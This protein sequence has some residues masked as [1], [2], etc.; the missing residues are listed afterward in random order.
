MAEAAGTPE[1]ATAHAVRA[2][3]V[4]NRARVLTA[5]REAFADEG[6]AVP[7]GEIARRAGVGAGTVYRHFPSKRDLFAAVVAQSAADQAAE[8]RELAASPDPGP[9]FFAFLARVVEVAAVNRALCDAFLHGAPEG[10]ES[11]AERRGF[12]EALGVL[13]SRA[14]QAGA[15]RADVTADD[16]RALLVGC[17]AMEQ[18]RGTAGPAPAGA[19]PGLLTSV[20]CDGLRARPDTKTLPV[21]PA[22]RNETRNEIGSAE[23][24]RNET[25]RCVVCDRPLEP[26]T[27]GRPA[28]YCGPACRQKAHRRRAAGRRRS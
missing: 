24:P 3:A 27:T 17:A 21:T 9:A 22:P 12:T 7:L 4:R 6:M 1:E 10:A 14:Q 2:D 8:A 15:V 19:V 18:Q 5:A 23:S 26:A 13:L 20:L 28:R 25:D 11:A 16:V